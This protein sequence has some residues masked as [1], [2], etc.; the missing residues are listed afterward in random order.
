MKQA[1]GIFATFGASRSG[2][3]VVHKNAKISTLLESVRMQSNLGPTAV[4]FR[5]YIHNTSLQEN[6][7]T[8]K[9]GKVGHP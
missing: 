8:E 3:N 5:G 1:I 4:S 9:N 7:S 2:S 6:Q